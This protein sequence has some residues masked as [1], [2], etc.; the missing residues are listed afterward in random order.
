[1]YLAYL[2]HNPF[3]ILFGDVST[4]SLDRSHEMKHGS[5]SMQG[6]SHHSGCLAPETITKIAL[7][8]IVID[9]LDRHA[10]L[11]LD[12]AIDLN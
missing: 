3:T 7:H 6:Y 10:V 8:W 1:M 9:V 5:P 12:G 11:S 2:F 4:S